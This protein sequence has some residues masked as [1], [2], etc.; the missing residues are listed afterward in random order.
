VH[1]RLFLQVFGQYIQFTEGDCV[2]TMIFGSLFPAS[3]VLM[4]SALF[5]VVCVKK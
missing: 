3:V 5:I 2:V 4:F 1:S